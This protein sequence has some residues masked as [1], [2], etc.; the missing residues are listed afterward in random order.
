MKQPSLPQSERLLDLLVER[1]TDH[2]SVGDQRELER[3]LINDQSVDVDHFEHA[4]AVVELAFLDQKYEPLPRHLRSGILD[5]AQNNQL[6]LSDSSRNNELAEPIA[7]P[8]KPTPSR[9]RWRISTCVAA[10]AAIVIA[11]T[12]W[13]PASTTSNLELRSRL[14]SSAK[15]VQ[16]IPWT[17]TSPTRLANVE[18]DVVWSTEAQ[19]GF[20][21][22]RGLPI[23]N[24]AEGQYQLWIVDPARD[25]HPID[26][27]VFN[28][29]TNGDVIVPINAKLKTDS[30]QVFAI[31]REKPGG[32]VVS[33]GPL[34]LVAKV[35]S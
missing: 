11:A 13:W 29:A 35:A 5:S 34:L 3:L 7:E 8:I 9:N 22:F 15:D 30:P 33:S 26:G 6:R 12:A 4:A 10:A 2:L 28:V 24:P 21:R 25:K 14:L 23:N 27:G 18:G 19:A 16:R 32:V 1:S 20:M 31:T 17:S